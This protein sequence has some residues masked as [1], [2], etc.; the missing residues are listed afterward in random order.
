MFRTD[1]I[2]HSE[3]A[4]YQTVWQVQLQKILAADLELAQAIDHILITETNGIPGTRIIQN[5][6]GNHN[7]SIGQNY[8]NAIGNVQGD[9]QL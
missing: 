8:G 1:T 3:N 4:A 6:V 5:V 7:Q 2:E 9:V